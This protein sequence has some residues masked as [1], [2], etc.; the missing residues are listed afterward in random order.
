VHGWATA[1]CP[2]GGCCRDQ[3]I[4]GKFI[5]WVQYSATFTIVLEAHNPSTLLDLK[6]Y[7]SH[8][9]RFEWPSWAI[10]DQNCR[11]DLASTNWAYAGQELMLLFTSSALWTW[12]QISPKLRT[13]TAMVLPHVS[14][15]DS[16]RQLSQRT[17]TPQGDHVQQE[18]CRKFNPPKGCRFPYCKYVHWCL[19]C[20]A[21]G[22]IVTMCLRSKEVIEPYIWCRSNRPLS[23]YL[24]IYMYTY[25]WSVCLHIA[26]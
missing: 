17:E 7:L 26:I 9:N 14:S 15:L 25:M 1:P 3:E 13:A 4:D 20:G 21:Q 8:A 12:H 2:T 6:I 10:Y 24:C 16:R 11:K 22:L 23:T 5:T 19:N 18:I